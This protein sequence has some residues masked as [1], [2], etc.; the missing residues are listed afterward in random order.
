MASLAL[1]VSLI[2]F[3]LLILGPISYILCSISWMP[4]FIKYILA[5]LCMGVGLW[6]LFIPIP[7]IK[8]LGLVNLSIGLKI[9]L[10]KET[11]TTQG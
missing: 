5:L 2:I 7:F 11:K 9:A 1:I 8:I 4:K 10:A 6:S 3:S